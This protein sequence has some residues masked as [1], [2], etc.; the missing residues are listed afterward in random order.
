[1][2]TKKV[3]RNKPANLKI[4]IGSGVQRR[5][6]FFIGREQI[7]KKTDLKERLS[8]TLGYRVTNA[9]LDDWVK[10]A[11]TEAPKVN[12]LNSITILGEMARHGLN[13][14]ALGPTAANQRSTVNKLL[15]GG[16]LVGPGALKLGNKANASRVYNLL[17]L[18]RLMRHYG[19]AYLQSHAGDYLETAGFAIGAIAASQLP[20]YF[21]SDM[22]ARWENILKFMDDKRPIV[23]LESDVNFTY[24][25]DPNNPITQGRGWMRRLLW[26][27]SNESTG[28]NLNNPPPTGN[29]KNW[30]ASSTLGYKG[31]GF[32]RPDCVTFFPNKNG[33]GKHECAIIE[34]KISDGK[35]ENI[36]GEYFQLMKIATDL[37]FTFRGMGLDVNLKLYFIPFGFG[38]FH[39]T[40]WKVEFFHIEARGTAGQKSV[41]RDAQTWAGNR[42]N[43]DVE[44][45]NTPSKFTSVT[46]M[47]YN[48]V[49]SAVL[50]KRGE[51]FKEIANMRKSIET[52]GGFHTMIPPKALRMARR[53]SKKALRL[54]TH[55]RPQFLSFLRN[56]GVVARSVANRGPTIRSATIKRHPK[57]PAARNAVS[58]IA[59]IA[60]S[61]KRGYRMLNKTGQP[62]A[63]INEM[64]ES[65]GYSTEGSPTGKLVKMA[66]NVRALRKVPNKY[67]GGAGVGIGLSKGEIKRITLNAPHW[68][69][70]IDKAQNPTE[71]NRI[72]GALRTARHS[73]GMKDTGSIHLNSIIRIQQALDVKRAQFGGGAGA[74]T[75][76]S[77]LVANQVGANAA[78]AAARRSDV[79]EARRRAEALVRS[80]SSPQNLGGFNMSE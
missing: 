45:L 57:H 54:G 79:E 23:I 16:V 47:D 32:G 77:R 34:L 22:N 36:P 9:I 28:R 62:L 70:L 2:T 50:S 13:V 33:P 66:H 26:M 10:Q 53:A 49:N 68:I 20:I 27:E 78:Q 67:K 56:K 59:K 72:S 30:K 61:S 73:K 65:N 31:H 41:L 24:I 46:G 48:V 42:I 11:R 76:A 38:L 37:D 4:L 74:I 43:Y 80:A 21:K 25:K 58:R 5:P 8:G 3:N 17:I 7:K 64:Y 40:N 29:A 51:Y 35:T 19:G 15:K 1:V 12:Q 63:P 60:R 44:V 52:T 75:N 18:D 14:K 55:G 39:Q 69:N 71:L 6:S